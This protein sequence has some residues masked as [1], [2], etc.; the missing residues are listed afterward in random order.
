MPL[1]N[2]S[3]LERCLSHKIVGF[4]TSGSSQLNYLMCFDLQAYK[5]VLTVYYA[6][7]PAMYVL[8][9]NIYT[10]PTDMQSMTPSS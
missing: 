9:H 6:H 3:V 4:G 1:S 7:I 2:P 5:L 10:S 8:I